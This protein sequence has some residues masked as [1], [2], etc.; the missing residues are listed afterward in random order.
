MRRIAIAG[1]QHETNTFSPQKT[2]LQDFIQADNWPRLLSGS[3]IFTEMHDLNIPLSGFIHQAQ[4]YDWQLIPLTWANA[5]PSGIVTTEAFNTILKNISEQLIAN[6]PVDAI[7]LDLHGAMV[8]ETAR[9][10]DGEILSHLRRI[11]GTQI[12]IIASLDLHANISSKMVAES[13]MLIAYRTYPHIDMA[14]TGERCAVA[15]HSIFSS[16]KKL[17]KIHQQLPFLIGMTAQSTL[18]HPASAIYQQ[19]IKIEHATQAHLSF[20]PGFPLADTYDTGPSVLAYAEEKTQ[21]RK[22]ANEL[23]DLILSHQND[24]SMTLLSSKQAVTQAKELSQHSQKSIILVDTQDNPGCGGSS[25]TTQLIIEMLNQQITDG[26]AGIICDPDVAE[27]AS[28]MGKGREIYAFLGAKKIIGEPISGLFKIINVSEGKFLATGPFYRNV[29]IDIGPTA[30]LS[31]NGLDIIVSSKKGQAA[32]QSMFQHLGLNP[33]TRKILALKS[34]VH[35]RA[36]FDAIASH[37]LIV[38]APGMNTADFHKLKYHH[39][40]PGIL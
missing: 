25:D 22:A 36:D 30:W 6:M 10:A 17:I 18:S 21:A 7:Y 9:D 38:E 31:L 20:A 37:H 29:L 24:F 4:Q 39:L 14:E 32:D 12:P 13:D 19:L 8:C 33:A 5:T 15:L 35:Y 40:R 1:F 3:E 16:Q 27:M 2:T 26:A 28:R 11:V 23:S 34:S